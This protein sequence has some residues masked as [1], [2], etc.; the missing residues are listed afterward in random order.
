MGKMALKGEETEI[1]ISVGHVVRHGLQLD[2]YVANIYISK[3][4]WCGNGSEVGGDIPTN[5]RM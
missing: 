1:N 4:C 2:L 3:V 5:Q